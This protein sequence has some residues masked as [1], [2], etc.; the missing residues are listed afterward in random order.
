LVYRK[1]L[2]CKPEMAASL[3]DLVAEHEKL[4][5]LTCNLKVVLDESRQAERAV[6]DHL[7]DR[8]MEFL[9][10]YRRHM[11][12]E[13]QH[14][15]PMALQ[16]LSPDDFAEI[17]FS[18]FDQPDPLVDSESEGM[19]AELREE[20]MRLAAAEEIS[21]DNRR[22][23]A[24]LAAIQD[25]AAFNEA[26]RRSG[27]PVRL[28]QSSQAGY[29]LEHNGNVLVH[30]PACSESRAAWC[31]YYYWKA[32]A[33][34]NAASRPERRIGN[35]SLSAGVGKLQTEERDKG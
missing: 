16:W 22:E 5:Q 24:L 7:T 4:S 11:L 25:L 13:D 2:G 1:L 18:L 6:G 10:L 3:K 23:T 28:V 32:T 9:G 14:F 33:L 30:I 26:M 34:R 8:L 17:D 20:I 29:E 27:D 31:A 21:S 15:F 19:F 12:M 35:S